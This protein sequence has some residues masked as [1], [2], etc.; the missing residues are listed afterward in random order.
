MD[1]LRPTV[2]KPGGLIPRRAVEEVLLELLITA[3][4]SVSPVE[5]IVRPPVRFMALKRAIHYVEGHECTSVQE[6][7]SYWGFRQMSQFALDYRWL[8]GDL[9]SATLKRSPGLSTGPLSPGNK[10]A[11]L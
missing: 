4:A 7:A 2:E 8:S 9:S 1:L 11:L 5:N 6:V 3:V 10:P